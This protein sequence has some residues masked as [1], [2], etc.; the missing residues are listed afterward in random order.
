MATTGTSSS[1]SKEGGSVMSS[2]EASVDVDAA[3]KVEGKDD[4]SPHVQE[5]DSRTVL[6][7][8]YFVIVCSPVYL[9]SLLLF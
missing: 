9:Y 3:E 6:N 7:G 2:H 1:D 5:R 8:Q 4:R